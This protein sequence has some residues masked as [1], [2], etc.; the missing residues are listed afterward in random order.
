MITRVKQIPNM[1]RWYKHH[2][3]G[4]K[5]VPYGQSKTKKGKTVAMMYKA[6][7]KQRY[8]TAKGANCQSMW[9]IKKIIPRQ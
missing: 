1:Q 3:S 5:G 8:P 2:V 7:Q 4:V 9:R 6:K